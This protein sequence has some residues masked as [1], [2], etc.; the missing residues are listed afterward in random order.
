VGAKKV[1]PTHYDDFFE[2]VDE[3]IEEV[4]AADLAEFID[5]TH[6]LRPGRGVHTLPIGVPVRLF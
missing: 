3:P 4:I 2:P 5:E 6:R 1:F